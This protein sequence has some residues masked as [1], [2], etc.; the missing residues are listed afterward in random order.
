MLQEELCT[1]LMCANVTK[2]GPE[3]M[4]TLDIELAF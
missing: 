3:Y 2:T 1:S 4:Y